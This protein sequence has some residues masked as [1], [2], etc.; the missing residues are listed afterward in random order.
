[1]VS[2]SARRGASPR[3]DFPGATSTSLT[4]INDASQ[5]V[6]YFYDSADIQHGFLA[7]PV[8]PIPEPSTLAVLGIGVTALGIIR[9][10]DSLHQL[11][12]WGGGA[13][14]H[15]AKRAVTMAVGLFDLSAVA[16]Y[17]FRNAHGWL[18]FN[19]LVLL[20]KY[21]YCLYLVHVLIF[22]HLHC[23]IVSEPIAGLVAIAV[24]LGIAALS[25]RFLERLKNR[26]RR[27]RDSEADLSSQPVPM[28]LGQQDRVAIS[29][30]AGV[31]L[32]LRKTAVSGR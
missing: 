19:A 12:F 6:G 2:F 13:L 25:W 30:G 26:T 24:S 22:A 32:R 14:V 17:A 4:G 8:T 31:P 16:V 11:T 10:R 28:T 21:S 29:H 7:T 18:T 1:M 15:L 20:G 9:R 23:A 27:A 3:S 5:I